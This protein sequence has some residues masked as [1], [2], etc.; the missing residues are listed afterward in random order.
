MAAAAWE[1][2]GKVVE[3]EAELR[4]RY[5]QLLMSRNHLLPESADRYAATDSIEAINA[6]MD[7]VAD[8]NES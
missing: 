4:K 2:T 6:Y 3:A 7:N 1:G 5:A 8:E